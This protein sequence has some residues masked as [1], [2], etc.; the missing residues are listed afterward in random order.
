MQI[1]GPTDVGKSSLAKLL[2]SYAVRMHWQPTMVDLDIGAAHPCLCL[3]DHQALDIWQAPQACQMPQCWRPSATLRNL[4][5]AE[6]PALSTA[7][8]PAMLF[9][10]FADTCHALQ[11]VCA[12]C[13]V[14][15]CLHGVCME[16]CRHSLADLISQAHDCRSCLMTCMVM[17]SCVAGQGAVTAPGSIAATPVENPVDIEEGLP[18]EARPSRIRPIICIAPNASLS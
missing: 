15:C 11:S 9:I 2:L 13:H 5:T 17:W 14:C 18:L 6:M 3:S 1:V 8:R 4:C 7:A 12:A 16:A 10:C